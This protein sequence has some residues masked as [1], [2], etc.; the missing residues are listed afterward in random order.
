MV[1]TKIASALEAV[2]E[3]AGR[4]LQETSPEAIDPTRPSGAWSARQ[5]LGHLIDSAANNH[6][7]FVRIQQAESLEFPAYDQR[8]WVACQHYEDRDW[9]ELVSLWTAYNRHLVHVLRAMPDEQ[10]AKPCRVV[11]NDASEPQ[12]L[13]EV[14]RS[15]V[16]HMRHHLAQ[17]GIGADAL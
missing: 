11:A 1:A 3:S 16:E 12:A 17:L 6:H 7:R 2:V 8:A 13:G 15:Y 14:A 9:A 5:I 4:R 10:L